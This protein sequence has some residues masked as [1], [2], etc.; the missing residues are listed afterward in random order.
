MHYLRELQEDL[1]HRADREPVG[2]EA[3]RLRLGIQ[4]AEQLRDCT[5]ACVRAFVGW[6]GWREREGKRERDHP[7]LKRNCSLADAPTLIVTLKVTVTGRQTPR[8]HLTAALLLQL[9]LP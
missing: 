1:L 2:P 6:L 7:Q 3:K 8:G 5:A 4:V 9:L